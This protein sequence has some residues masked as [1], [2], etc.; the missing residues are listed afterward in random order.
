MKNPRHQEYHDKTKTI[1]GGEGQEKQIKGID[2]LFNKIIAE[3]SQ[4]LR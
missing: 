1:R 3:T 4:I 2:N